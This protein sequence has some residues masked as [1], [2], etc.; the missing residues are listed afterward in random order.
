MT[1]PGKPNKHL[2]LL[3]VQVSVSIKAPPGAKIHPRVMQQILDRAVKGEPL[4]PTVELRGIFWR[5]PNRRG[6]LSHWRYHA[7]ADV[8]KVAPDGFIDGVPVET[9]PRG[10]LQDAIDTL[11]G[12]L[13]SG[14]VS[15]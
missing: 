14:T 3:Q 9:S 13:Y 1:R 10:S 5:N 2:D 8:A 11:S 7:G 12:A 6:S 15:F 4:P